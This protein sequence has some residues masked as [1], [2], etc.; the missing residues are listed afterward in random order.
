MNRRCS[1]PTITGYVSLHEDLAN[2]SDNG[3]V[4]C[5][6]QVELI[7]IHPGTENMDRANL[8]LRWPGKG[9]V[10]RA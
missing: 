5:G 6:D 8:C 10:R 7:T 1:E 9:L 3:V 2:G 4:I